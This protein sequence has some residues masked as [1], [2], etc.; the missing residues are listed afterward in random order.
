MSTVHEIERAVSD[1]SAEEL[2]RFR[3][4]FLEFDALLW[5]QQFESDAA[6]GR[7]RALADEALSDFRAGRTTPL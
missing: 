6:E 3:A 4:W 1:L 2:S 7:L 5:D